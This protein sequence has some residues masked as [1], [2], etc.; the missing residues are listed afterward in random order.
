MSA[1]TISDEQLRQIKES[2]QKI[3]V[4]GDGRLSVTELMKAQQ[5][6]GLNPTRQETREMVKQVDEDSSGYIEFDEYVALMSERVG[7]LEYEKIQLESAFRHFDKDHSGKLSRDELRHF[8]TS[9]VGE[10]LTE[11][12]F[13]DVIK[14]MDQDGDGMVDL[15]EFCDMLCHRIST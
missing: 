9:N 11:E 15:T 1:V 5:A 3:D 2:F 13:T 10:P 12:E 8:L 14:D 6:L 7:G 4:N